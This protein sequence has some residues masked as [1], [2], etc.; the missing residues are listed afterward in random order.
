MFHNNLKISETPLWKYLK[1]HMKEIP[2]AHF[3]LT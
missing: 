2:R 1:Q 3:K